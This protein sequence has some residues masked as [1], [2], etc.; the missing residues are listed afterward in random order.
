MIGQHCKLLIQRSNQWRCYRQLTVPD[1]RVWS[2]GERWSTR[3]EGP[4]AASNRHSARRRPRR[5]AR[6]SPISDR[7][8]LTG[9]GW[10]QAGARRAD[11]SEKTP[12]RRSG[13]ADRPGSNTM[14]RAAVVATRPRIKPSPAQRRSV[15]TE[16]CWT[17]ERGA[18][19]TAVTLDRC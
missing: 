3:V 8:W 19:K 10:R 1:S 12:S 17:A 16:V 2:V 6:Q 18:V 5:P 14:L 15:A 9:P 13:G 4:R 11:W 7:R